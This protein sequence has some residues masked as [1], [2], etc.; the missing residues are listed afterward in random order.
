[1]SWSVHDVVQLEAA[2]VPTVVVVT[3]PFSELAAYAA[4]SEALPESRIAVIAHPLGGVTHDAV[5]AKAADAVE[6]VLALLTR[7]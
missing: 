4:H 3:E 5:V 6:T 1:V 7:E 2:G